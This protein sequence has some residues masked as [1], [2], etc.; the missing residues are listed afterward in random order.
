MRE[1]NCCIRCG[2]P[3]DLIEEAWA[4]DKSV[5]ISNKGEYCPRCYHDLVEMRRTIS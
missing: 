5:F 1:T 2:Q 3:L 4:E